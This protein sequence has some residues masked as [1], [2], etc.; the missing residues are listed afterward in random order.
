M[1]ISY[2]NERIN[3]MKHSILFTVCQRGFF[4]TLSTLMLMTACLL[5][6]SP[7]AAVQPPYQ[8]PPTLRAADLLPPDML[9]GPLFQVDNQVPTDGLMGHFTLRSQWGNFVVPGKDL[10]RVR[11]AELPAIQQLENMSSSQVFLDAVGRAAAKPVEA[12]ANM[13][14]N[15]VQTV[16][17]L[18]SG[19]F[20]AVRPG[21]AGCGKSRA[22]RN[23][24]RQ[25]RHSAR[26]RDGEP[27]GERHHQR[28]GV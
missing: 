16:T 19:H 25:E 17:N 5:P 8:M 13:V 24:L 28:T 9:A 18:P 1:N 12:A 21:G 10:L 6:V 27:G 15:P 7:A 26:G 14:A 4:V 2:G 22:G 3:F 11:I 20:A 23:R